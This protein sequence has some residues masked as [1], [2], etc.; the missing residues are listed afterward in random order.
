[1]CEQKKTD[2]IGKHEIGVLIIKIVLF[3]IDSGTGMTAYV[4]FKV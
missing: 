2:I 1:M 4:K 3:V